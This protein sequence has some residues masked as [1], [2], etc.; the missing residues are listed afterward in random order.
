MYGYVAQGTGVTLVTYREAQYDGLN[1]QVK[2]DYAYKERS[3]GI[4]VG[5]NT[6]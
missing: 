6:Y 2:L 5:Q 3:P 4:W 1:H